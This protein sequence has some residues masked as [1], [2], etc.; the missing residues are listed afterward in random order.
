MNKVYRAHPLMTLSLMKPFLFILIFP[1]IKGILR[2]V[3][4]RRITGEI[5][6]E[7]ILFFIIAIT[8]VLRC[9]AFKLVV[10]N[11]KIAIKSGI[12]FVKRATIKISQLSSVQSD[13]NILDAVFSSVT[14][15]INTEAGRK[16]SIDFKFK[17]RLSDSK[18]ISK[19]LYGDETANKVKF[20]ALKIAALAATTSSAFTG[21]IIG[22]PIIN[23]V[24]NLLGVALNEMLFDEIN[25]V[26]SKFETYLPPIVNAVSLLFLLAYAISFLYSFLK[27]INFR[28]FLGEEKLEVRSGFFTRTRTSFKKST[29]NNVVVEQTPLM[30]LFRLYSMK[31][32]VGGYGDSKSASEIIVPSGKHREIER[33]F[34]RYFPFFRSSGK[35]LRPPRN[36]LTIS[37]FL[38]MPGI[39]LLLLIF[40]AI[41]LGLIF[42]DFGRLIFFLSFL[43]FLVIFYFANLSLREYR[44][45][46]LRMGQTIFAGGSKRLRTWELYCPKENIGE[47]KITRFFT[48]FWQNTC[49]VRVTVRSERADNICIR[50]LD[51][52][53]VIEEIENCFNIHGIKF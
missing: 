38:L 41:T 28:L 39:Y 29:V 9:R 49:R 16:N 24:G 10:D 50:M 21:M 32:S 30:F 25:N 15:S 4:N 37:R 12:F 42:K 23:R 1:F 33:D 17:L 31:V 34:S 18:E 40:A 19:L 20:S 13:R 52:G 47:I 5:I 36:K 46:K 53:Q 7:V 6:I 22:V 3:S 43:S 8:A 48:D 35:T 26:S 27:Y 11:D 44:I 45:G 2:Y 14:Y 51:Y